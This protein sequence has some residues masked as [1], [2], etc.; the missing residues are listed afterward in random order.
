VA[1]TSGASAPMTKAAR[2]PSVFR[3]DGDTW[4]VMCE[5]RAFHLRDAKGLRYLA[6][7]LHHPGREFPALALAAGVDPEDDSSAALDH[8]RGIHVSPRLGDAGVVLDAQARSEYRGRLADLH[9]ILA[10]AERCNDAGRA[11][12]AREEI[13]FLTAELSRAIGL[14]GRNRKAGSPAERARL[15]VT[16]AIKSALKRIA[17]NDATLG[18]HLAM[19]VKTGALCTYTPDPR[20]PIEWTR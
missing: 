15:S 17:E 13:E 14:G 1:G 19:T 20:S 18:R 2:T 8:E 5:G 3:R 12:A 4:T 9:A 16:M 6:E 10:D 7:L 11:T